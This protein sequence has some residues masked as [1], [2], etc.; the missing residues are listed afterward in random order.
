M[1]SMSAFVIATFVIVSS[2]EPVFGEER[3]TCTETG[4]NVLSVNIRVPDLPAE[5]RLPTSSELDHVMRP[6]AL[7]LY[8]DYIDTGDIDGDGML[9]WVVLAIS[10]DGARE[11]ALAHLSSIRAWVLIDEVPVGEPIKV[12]MTIKIIESAPV[13]ISYAKLGGH[14]TIYKWDTGQKRLSEVLK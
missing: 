11:G 3:G 4:G 9:D 2:A 12:G 13:V 5:W 8:P 6:Q 10:A 14:G 7:D 1:N